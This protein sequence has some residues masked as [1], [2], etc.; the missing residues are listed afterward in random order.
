MRE[1]YENPRKK[2]VWASRKQTY[3][4]WHHSVRKEANV[5]KLGL[6]V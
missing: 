3:R 4:G 6:S 2:S 1:L 5:K